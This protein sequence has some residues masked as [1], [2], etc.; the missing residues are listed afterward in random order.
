MAWSLTKPA[1][2]FDKQ[3]RGN[4]VYLLD[5][6]DFFFFTRRLTLAL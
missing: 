2:Q 1:T 3:E 6:E 4:V 5:L